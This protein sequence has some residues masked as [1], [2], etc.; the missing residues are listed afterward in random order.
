MKRIAL[1]LLALSLALATPVAGLAKDNAG[2]TPLQAAPA[3]LRADA[4]YLLL[5]TSKAKSGLFAIQHVLLRNPHRAGDG[6]LSGCQE[7]R[8]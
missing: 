3:A 6:R 4:A 8:L 1:C 2:V 5:R 7:A